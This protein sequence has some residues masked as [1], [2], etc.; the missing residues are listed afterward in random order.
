[1]G[2]WGFSELTRLDPIT[3]APSSPMH[4]KQ[5]LQRSLHQPLV[6]RVTRVSKSPRRRQAKPQS[7]G[8]GAVGRGG[9]WGVRGGAP[10]PVDGVRVVPMFGM[11]A[12]R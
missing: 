5:A 6:P 3:A 7:A 12:G 1:V 8:P 9:G 11:L 2:T 4:P 10:P